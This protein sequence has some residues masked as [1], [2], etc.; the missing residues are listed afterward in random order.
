MACAFCVQRQPIL[1][2]QQ[3]HVG[4]HIE[5]GKISAIKTFLHG[6]NVCS[7]IAQHLRLGYLNF[8]QAIVTEIDHKTR[9]IKF[10][11]FTSREATLSTFLQSLRKAIIKEGEMSFD[12]NLRD[13]DMVIVIH[14][15]RGS[16]PP[17]SQEIV[18]NARR[19]LQEAESGRNLLISNCEHLANL[20]VTQQRVSLEILNVRYSTKGILRRIL[21]IRPLWFKRLVATM[22]RKLTTIVMKLETILKSHKNKKLFAAYE[23][24]K[25]FIGKW[26]ASA[27]TTA[28]MFLAVDIYQFYSASKHNGLCKHCFLRWVTRIILRLLS[29]L[30]ST[31]SVLLGVIVCCFTGLMS[32]NVLSDKKYTRL[33]TLRTIEPGNVITFNLHVPFSFHDAIVVSLARQFSAGN[34]KPL[35]RPFQSLSE[36]EAFDLFQTLIEDFLR[37]ESLPSVEYLEFSV[38][39][40]SGNTAKEFRRSNLYRKVTVYVLLKERL[41]IKKLKT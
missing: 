11:E 6:L 35:T 5:F 39:D 9:K 8:H 19:L 3:L 24:I 10:V 13:I 25:R 31:K 41:Q 23:N 30:L 14:R 17:S 18:K 37:N 32:Y 29:T 38:Q 2:L 33:S 40:N 22:T 28:V 4:D 1:N 15:N 7:F 16:Y 21:T 20:C 26:M 36:Q 12:D 27:L 34:M